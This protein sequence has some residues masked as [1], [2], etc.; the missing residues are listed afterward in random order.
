MK[1][2]HIMIKIYSIQSNVDIHLDT[3]DEVIYWL[4]NSSFLSIRY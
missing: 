3:A 4:T 1:K 2:T